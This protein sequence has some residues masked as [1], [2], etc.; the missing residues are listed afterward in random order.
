MLERILGRDQSV[1]IVVRLNPALIQN[2]QSLLSDFD[3]RFVIRKLSAHD[4]A[5]RRAEVFKAIPDAREDYIRECAA[6][7]RGSRPDGRLGGG[8]V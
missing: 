6:Q 8:G 7:E 1:D 5:Q 4:T 3:A 2:E